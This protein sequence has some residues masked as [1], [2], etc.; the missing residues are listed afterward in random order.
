MKT[1]LTLLAVFVFSG[2]A[3]ADYT[4]NYGWEGTATIMGQYGDIIASISTV[5]VHGGDQSLYLVDDQASGTPQAY[6]AWVVGL[7]D[8]DEVTGSFWRYDTTPGSS[9]S[10]RI[11]GNWN[12]DPG[13]INGYNGS[14][15]Y[16][17][18]YGPGTGWDETSYVWTVVDG[19]TGLVITCRTYSNPGDDVWL[20]DMSITVPDHA[21][22]RTPDY[23]PIH[24]STWGD[25]KAAF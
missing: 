5:Q 16:N 17:S 18:D 15:G 22:V 21:T 10:C 9:P 20:D 12:D 23:V 11:S 6:V 14:A 7:L 4:V 25:I 24:R 8:G 3:T 2:I 13:D 19:H 1:I